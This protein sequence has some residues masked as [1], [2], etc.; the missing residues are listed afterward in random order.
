MGGSDR[1][2]MTSGAGS[3]ILRADVVNL[4]IPFGST[5]RSPGIWPATGVG[6]ALRP[7]PDL[8]KLILTE[9]G[10]IELDHADTV[11]KAGQGF[12]ASTPAT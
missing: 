4:T 5:R 8:K 11:I 9:A 3:G 1:G 7:I 2:G 12:R 10:Q 6:M